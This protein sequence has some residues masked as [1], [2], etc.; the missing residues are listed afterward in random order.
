MT[1]LLKKKIV[2]LLP[3]ILAVLFFTACSESVT[4]PIENNSINIKFPIGKKAVYA[5]GTYSGDVDSLETMFMNIYSLQFD[6]VLTKGNGLEYIG[7]VEYSGRSL[8]DSITSISDLG[9]TSGKIVVSVDDKWVLFQQSEVIGS[10]QIFMKR[11][12][13]G[14]DTTLIPTMLENQFPVFP[15]KIKPNTFYSVYRPSSSDSL[16]L[17]P[18]ER[19]LAVQR[20]FDVKDYT[21]W[22]DIYGNE[23]GL[24]YKTEH[25]LKLSQ[26][27]TIDFAGIIDDKGVVVSNYTLKTVIRT[28]ENPLGGDSITTHTINRRIVDFTDPENVKELSWYADYV[29]EN[30][31]E[32]LGEQ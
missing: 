10:G 5:V 25:V 23:K 14:T 24:F 7:R 27:L 6:T 12:S 28:V 19:F 22:S 20:D 30:G 29:I 15:K 11:N 31:L 4:P 26:E 13:S 2:I 9:P 18:F 21:E 16:S 32:L 1:N 8:M 3:I 17:R